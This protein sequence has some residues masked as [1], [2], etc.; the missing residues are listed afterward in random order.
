[1]MLVLMPRRIR[2]Q[3]ELLLGA[4]DNTF[5]TDMAKYCQMRTMLGVEID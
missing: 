4:A 1:M 3:L 2:G 5:E